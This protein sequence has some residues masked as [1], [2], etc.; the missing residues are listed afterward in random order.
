MF[1]TAICWN[2]IASRPTRLCYDFDD[3]F[4]PE[5]L[6]IAS[7]PTRLCYDQRDILKWESE[8]ATIGADLELPFCKRKFSRVLN[9][10]RS[11]SQAVSPL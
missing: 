2:V 6:V 7:R 3:K 5:K 8:I 1:S 10:N 9:Q 4:E 11:P